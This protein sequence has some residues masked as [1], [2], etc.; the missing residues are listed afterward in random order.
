MYKLRIVSM[1]MAAVLLCSAVTAHAAPKEEA[2]RFGVLSTESSQNL[3]KLWAPFLQDMEKVL[4]RPVQAFFASDYAGLI[5]GMRFNKVD[6]CWLGGKAAIMAVDR[7][8]GEVFAQVTDADGVD[9]YYSLLVA[10]KDSPLNNVQDMLANAKNLS[11]SNGDPNSTSGFL[12]PSYYV[13]AQNGVDA[14]KIFKNVVSA[15]HESNAL[16][17]ANK[18]VDVA[19]FNSE[20]LQRLQIVQPAKAEMLKII[21]TS[22]LIPKDPLVWRK[23]LDEDTK[24]QIVDFV[25]SYGTTGPDKERQVAVLNALKW[26]LFKKSS[27]AQ[28][29][30]LRKLEFFREK[31]KIESDPN[32]SAEEKNQK[33]AEIDANLA[34]LQ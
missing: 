7:A 29:T 18:Q 34:K 10:H 15:N 23:D 26:G 13:F 25:L 12:V 9:G 22:P 4:N 20:G 27:N 33:L 6:L 11:F 14:K 5:E 21:W 3:K 28:L 1:C 30:P 2:L 8:N 32:L 24:K 19:T 31:T 17:V 16:A